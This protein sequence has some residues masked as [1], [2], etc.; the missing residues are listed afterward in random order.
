MQAKGCTTLD[1]ALHAGN[2]SLSSFNAQKTCTWFP[3]A[4]SPYKCTDVRLRNLKAL[5]V[6]H[7]DCKGVLTHC[8]VQ[9]LQC[10]NAALV[11][12]IHNYSCFHAPGTFRL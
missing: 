4:L 11:Y 12:I 7:C 6:K 2:N 5:M 3:F 1:R 9:H 10:F 8:M